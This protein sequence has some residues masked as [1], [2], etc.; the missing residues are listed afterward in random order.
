[1]A[2]SPGSLLVMC[3]ITNPIPGQVSARVGCGLAPH[4]FCRGPHK[5]PSRRVAWEDREHNPVLHAL[6]LIHV[7]AWMIQNHWTGVMVRD[8][9]HE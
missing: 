8:H 2:D 5:I 4:R 9:S 7:T 1:M 3:Q 6:T